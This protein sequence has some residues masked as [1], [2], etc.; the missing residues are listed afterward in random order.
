MNKARSDKIVLSGVQNY[1][2][3]LHKADQWSAQTSRRDAVMRAQSWTGRE[4]CMG[5][6]PLCY[7]G[8]IWQ[9]CGKN[10]GLTTHMRY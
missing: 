1:H 7:G 4:G 10:T 5:L 8:A 6:V 3:N 9:K 2:F